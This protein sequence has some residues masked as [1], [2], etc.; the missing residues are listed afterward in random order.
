MLNEVCGLYKLLS[1]S[2]AV[3]L[4]ILHEGNQM[5]FYLLNVG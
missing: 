1:L 3:A 5:C 2:W 4:C